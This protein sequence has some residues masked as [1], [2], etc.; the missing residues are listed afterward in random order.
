MKIL[1]IS[2]IVLASLLL[3]GVAGYLYASSGI[4]SKPGYAALA[5][6]KGE[7]GSVLFS[8][9]IGPSGIKPVR[10]LF[11]KFADDFHHVDQASERM[12]NSALQ[13]L[14]GVQLRVY[15]VDGSRDE[16]DDA[17][18]D[19][20]T[21][22]KEKNWETLATVREDNV[23]ITVLQYGDSR[24]I[25]G[26]SIMAS[27]PDKAIFFNLIGPFDTEGIAATASKYI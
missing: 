8:I 13:E 22:L 15:D 18:V 12:L 11:D 14:Q 3:V 1:K 20:V 9:N 24:H 10:W 21:A 26:L 6:S 2:L 19:L 23:T 4:K 27:T 17:I 16:F 7:L 25:A 5:I